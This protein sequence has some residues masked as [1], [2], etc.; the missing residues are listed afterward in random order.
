MAE[1]WKFILI[2]RKMC[3]RGMIE[4]MSENLN[5]NQIDSVHNRQTLF[6]FSLSTTFQLKSTCF[7][8]Y[9]CYSFVT[10]L[11]NCLSFCL[12]STTLHILNMW[13]S[14]ISSSGWHLYFK[15]LKRNKKCSSQ[16]HV[17]MSRINLVYFLDLRYSQDI[18]AT[19]IQ[20]SLPLKNIKK[21]SRKLFFV[22]KL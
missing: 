17:T 19:F 2:K 5:S 15:W 20:S 1:W 18:Q 21:L 4:G 3:T 9:T 8:S 13:K 16:F 7:R 11:T 22:Q 10:A 14:N 6:F 12:F